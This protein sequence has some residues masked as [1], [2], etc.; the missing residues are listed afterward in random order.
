MSIKLKFQ[1][2]LC[3]INNSI[4]HQS[5][6]Y[7]HLND[8]TVLFQTIR[9]SIIIQFNSIW[10]INRTLSGVTTPSQNGPESDGNKGVLRLPQSSSITGTSP[11]DCLVSYPGHSLGG[12]SYPSAEMQVVYST[13]PVDW[14][15]DFFIKLISLFIVSI[16]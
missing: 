1:V 10:P 3:I 15:T 8:Q 5:F 11:S 13:S 2:F 6:V 4:K 14:A 12:G 7:T 16:F 9:F